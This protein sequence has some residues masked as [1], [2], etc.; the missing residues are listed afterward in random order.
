MSQ[1]GNS[2]SDET[3]QEN[4]DHQFSFRWI[5]QLQWVHP[6]DIPSQLKDVQSRLQQ[7]LVRHWRQ[8]ITGDPD[9]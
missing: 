3:T 7:S 6:S 8:A 9:R 2:S 5:S 1:S 4:M